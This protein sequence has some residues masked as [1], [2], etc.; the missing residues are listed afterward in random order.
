VVE[1]LG[2][3][4][5]SAIRAEDKAQVGVAVGLAW[6]QAGGDILSIETSTMKGKGKLSLT[7][8]LGNVM[9]ESA[10]AGYT[11]LR[12]NAAALRIPADF[13]RNT[14]LHVHV[15]EGAIPKD[16]PS[17]GVTMIVSMLSALTNRAP[18]PALAMTGE[19]TLRGRVLAVGGIKEKVIAAHRAGIRHI[20]MPKENEKDFPDIPA[21]VRKDIKFTLVEYVSEVVKIAFAEHDGAAAGADV[22]E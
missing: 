21:E 10:E 20:L 17:A 1:L 7:G 15:P 3:P 8:Q 18:S 5:Y 16:G 22:K 4:P 2:P 6:T 19:I 11:Y 14:D 9:K 13:Y 12:A